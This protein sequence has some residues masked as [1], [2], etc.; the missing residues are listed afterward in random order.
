[1]HFRN[2]GGIRTGELTVQSWAE[3]HPYH[4]TTQADKILISWFALVV[5]ERATFLGEGASLRLEFLLTFL[6][7]R[8]DPEPGPKVGQ[9]CDSWADSDPETGPKSQNL[10]FSVKFD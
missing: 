8:R 6:Y 3:R 7:D 1:M 10:D 5:D 2:P 9:F 4:W